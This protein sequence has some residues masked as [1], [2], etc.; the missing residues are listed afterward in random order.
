MSEWKETSFTSNPRDIHQPLQRV[1]NESSSRFNNSMTKVENENRGPERP[2]GF[3]F[4]IVSVNNS[5]HFF[6][7][8]G[9]V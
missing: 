6:S 4:W 2:R 5:V 8:K 3:I 7:L 1:P 9:K